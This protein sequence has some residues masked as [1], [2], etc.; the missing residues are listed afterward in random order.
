MAKRTYYAGDVTEEHI[1][2]TVTLKGWVQKR[3]D[4]GNLIFIDLRD[5]AGIV[6]LVFSQEINADAWQLLKTCAVNM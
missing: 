1:G 3:R 5:R 6:Q 4:L 2:E